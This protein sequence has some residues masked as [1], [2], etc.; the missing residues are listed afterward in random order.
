MQ[1]IFEKLII[2]FSTRIPLIVAKF[3]HH[4]GFVKLYQPLPHLFITS[5]EYS[6]R[7]TGRLEAIQENLDANMKIGM[8]IGCN[9]GFYVFSLAETGRW[10]CGV[11]GDDSVFQVFLA[12]KRKFLPGNVTPINMHVTPENVHV[13]PECDFVIFMA[14]FHHWARHYGKDA[15]LQMLS[16][17][18]SK[19]RQTL[20]LEVPFSND[21]GEN[22]RDVLPDRDAKDPEAW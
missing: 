14:V 21:S 15:A 18:L 13:L 19:T 10:M 22:Y 7:I 2:L 5:G 12:A 3:F 6:E 16:I 20:F 4:T 11:E 9:N 17:L 1:S 8:D